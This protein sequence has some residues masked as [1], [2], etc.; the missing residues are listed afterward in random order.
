[1]TD[2][3][4]FDFCFFKIAIQ[5]KKYLFRNLPNNEGLK[6]SHITFLKI[7]IMFLVENILGFVR[8]M[9]TDKDA[10]TINANFFLARKVCTK[11]FCCF[12]I[13]HSWKLC[14]AYI[15]GAKPADFADG[16]FSKLYFAQSYQLITTILLHL[17]QTMDFK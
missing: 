9:V 11:F 13:K 2:E 15:L 6:K 4:K 10:D 8:S 17:I 3:I 16:I 5:I 14:F 12:H 1:M 7:K